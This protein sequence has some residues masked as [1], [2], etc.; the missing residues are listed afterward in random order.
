[1]RGRTSPPATARRPDL[2]AAAFDEEGF[3]R[4][5]D[6]LVPVDPADPHRGF[7]FDGRL[8][9]DFKLTTGS[10]SASVP[11]GPPSSTRSSRWCATSPSRARRG[12][13][14]PALV[15]PDIAA[16][17]ALCG[18]TGDDA[19]ILAHPALRR[20]FARRLGAFAQR[21]T[22]SSNRIARLLLLAEPPALDRDEVTDKGSIN[23]RGVLRNRAAAVDLL[24]AAPFEAAIITPE[25]A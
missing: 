5:G 7:A 3:Y 23:Q 11:C 22:G 9:E 1:M 20:D 17:R 15:F 6:A 8:N 13:R 18:E 2:T 10:G 21:A 24:Y 25:T 4:L 19:R 16:C 14:S 12:T